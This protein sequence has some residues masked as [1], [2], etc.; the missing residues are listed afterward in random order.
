MDERFKLLGDLLEKLEIKY[1]EKEIDMFAMYYDLLI[2]WNSRMNLTAITD[3]NEVI[4]KHFVDS[5]LICR[6]I[7]LNKNV[8]LIDVGSGAGFPGILNPECRVLLLDSLNKRVG[9]LSHVIN[10]LGLN[11]INC[12]HGRAEDVSREKEFRGK[13]DYSVSRAVA[14]LSTLSEYC[15]PFLKVGGRFISYKSDKS[16]DE[17]RNSE[18]AIKILGSKILSV[19]DIAV[20]NNDL[21]RR[22]IIIENIEPVSK[23][24]PRKAGTPIKNPL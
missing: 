20:P 10:S 6:F 17:I 23:K 24:Y 16:D 1:S 12:L 4:V 15:I 19:E 2:D 3:L 7:D 22:F 9:F 11:N 18:N 13:F 14:N 8:S 21:N 5:V